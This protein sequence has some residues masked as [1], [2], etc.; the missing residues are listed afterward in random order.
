MQSKNETYD[1]SDNSDD[2]QVRPEETLK[3]KSKWANIYGQGADLISDRISRKVG[4]LDVNGG[5]QYSHLIGGEGDRGGRG[6]AKRGGRGG[7]GRGGDR[8][9]GA[10]K[11]NYSIGSRKDN[12]LNIQ[13]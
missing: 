1:S 7:R 13:R 8:G 9:R 3:S 4:A 5:G 6:R 12:I 2:D 10:S 11:Q